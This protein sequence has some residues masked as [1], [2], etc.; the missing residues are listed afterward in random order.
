MIELKSMLSYSLQF[1][2]EVS[3]FPRKTFRPKY[4]GIYKCEGSILAKEN[5]IGKIYSF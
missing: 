1:D 5:D 3:K 2:A 4:M